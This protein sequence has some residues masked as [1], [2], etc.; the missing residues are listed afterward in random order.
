MAYT[1]SVHTS[2]NSFYTEFSHLALHTKPI[3]K[4]IDSVERSQ[5]SNVQNYYVATFEDERLLCMSY[6][7]LLSVKPIHFNIS[8]KKIQQASLSLAL[9]LVKPTLLVAGN[10]FRHDVEFQQFMLNDLTFEQQA[11]IFSATTDH[12]IS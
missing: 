6:Y 2:F 11:S 8:D 1:F 12:M 3:C 7:Q 10:L 9:R 4:G 5:V